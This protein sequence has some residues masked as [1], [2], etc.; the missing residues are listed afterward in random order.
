MENLKSNIQDLAKGGEQLIN[1]YVKLLGVRQSQK[2][3]IF[4]G[5]IA[6]VFIISTLLLIVIVF[7]S[8]V[9]ANY[10]SAALQSDYMG[11]VIIAVLYLLV[12]LILLLVMKKTGRPLLFNLLVKSVLPL[13]GVEISQKPTFEGLERE[14]E[15]LK[16]KISTDRSLI[17]VQSQLLKYAIIEDL[18]GVI[19]GLFK[20][21]S[22]RASEESDSDS[23]EKPS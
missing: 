1:N 15:M 14:K 12:I 22:S 3:A 9:L 10:L 16:E 8:L 20:S 21:K 18:I 11:F 23:E 2:L 4:L 13:L 19:L 7:A 6:S 17:G 5:L